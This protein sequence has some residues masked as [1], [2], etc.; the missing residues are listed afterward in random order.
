MTSSCLFRVSALFLIAPLLTGCPRQEEASSQA[1]P[2]VQT[3][4]LQDGI[5]QNF[6]RFPGEVLAA[7]TSEM[8]F[9]VAGRLIERPAVQG[10]VAVK[11]TLLARV[12]PENFEARVASANAR[13]TNARDEL[14]RRRQLRDRGVISATE[15]DQFNTEFQVA[16]AAQREA[17]RALEDTRLVAPFDGRV[18]R[19]FLNVGTSVQP[20]QPVLVYQDISRLEIDI[21]VPEQVM[22][23]FGVG[24]TAENAR[25]LLEAQAEFPALPG[26][27]FDV[28]LKSFS[29][30]ATE[31]ARTF[32]VSFDLEPPADANILP[33]VTCTVLVR[34]RDS[35]QAPQ[36]AGVFEVPT[37]AVG[38]AEGKAFLWRLDPASLTVSTVGVEL[39]GP[40]GQSMRV[41]SAD[42][43]PGDEIVIAGVRFLSDGMKVGRTSVPA[44]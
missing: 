41:R 44:R 18:A 20:K 6:R 12:D 9:D 15:F 33:G 35:G 8:S 28:A 42:L 14:A 22:T 24:A 31:A 40:A 36:D 39:L 32:R 1:I 30:A 34:S 27:R 11:G 43:K 37:Q 38:T 7:R 17:Q 16:E 13:L 4:V 2:P 19:T 10:M 26:R 5:A 25:E 21:E 3:L 29:T 23:S